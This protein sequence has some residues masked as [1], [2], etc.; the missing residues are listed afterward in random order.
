VRI[1]AAPIALTLCLV[2]LLC[3]CTAADAS[4]PTIVVDGQAIQ[5]DVPAIFAGDHVLVPLRDIVGRLGGAVDF[6]S[7]SGSI[8]VHRGGQIVQLALGSLVAYADGRRIPLDVAP[9]EFAGRIMVPLRILTDALGA[10]ADYNA[11]TNAVAI[12]TNV[13]PGA[14][15]AAVGSPPRLPSGYATSVTSVPVAASYV[16]DERPASDSLV[17]TQYP[18]IYGRFN[19]GS[20]A[21][22]PSTVGVTFDG[23]DVTAES[24]VSSA[25]FAYT[26]RYALDSGRHTVSVTGQ[27][28]DGTPFSDSWTFR[29]DA[30][31]LS[32]VSSMLDYGPNYYYGYRHY[33]FC[34]PGFALYA[35][36]PLFLVAGNVVEII[37]FSRF[38]PYGT[39]WVTVGGLPGQFYLTPWPGY[40]GYFWTT[41]VVPYGVASRV[42]VVSAHFTLVNGKTVVVHS[43]APLTIDGTRR[44]LPNSVRY[45]VMPSLINQP[46]SPRHLV[47]Y[48]RLAVQPARI[49][50]AGG[51]SQAMRTTLPVHAPVTIDPVHT[52]NV[53]QNQGGAIAPVSGGANGNPVVTQ[54]VTIPVTQPGAPPKPVEHSTQPVGAHPLPNPTNV[55]H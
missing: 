18:Q 15:V 41:A 19:G 11:E 47:V 34:P 25:Y 20:T 2:A 32:Y 46:S 1:N 16:S 40:P 54:P 29:V 37:F 42:A 6:D 17:G 30:G 27:N 51:A 26:P 50:T 44:T 31:S 24:T 35:P 3:L 45:A 52:G 9:R 49:T 33:G 4:S 53:P 39:G 8:T 10:S 28:D 23:A 12:V 55:P 38:Y 48:D 36:G 13:K 7:A 5:T 22:N 14:F 43:T 21:V